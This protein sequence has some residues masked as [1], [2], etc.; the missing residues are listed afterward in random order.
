MPDAASV[1]PKIEESWKRELGAEFPKPYFA[2]LKEFLLE[3]K[4]RGVPV[5]PPGPL[6]FNAFNHTPFD[7][8][9]VVILGQD[10]YHGPGQAHGLCF[11]VPRG[12]RP[13]PSLQNIF[14]ELRDDIGFRIPDHGN[15]EAWADR[16]VFLLNATLTVR[17]GSPGSH[18]G[19][20]WEE[21]TASAVSAL[22]ERREGIVFLLWGRHAIAKQPLIDA[23]R[24]HVLTAPHPSPFSADRG[25]FGCRHFSRTNAIL[26]DSGN[27]PV[28]WQI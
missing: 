14:K 18:Q 27:E 19:K 4:R 3:E 13:P 11:S 1:D 26:R 15:L 24:H 2:A 9:K 20:G 25:F 8:V 21:F 23:V 5:Y 22:S 10:P 7:K 6:I 28:E 12:V 17:G 16:G